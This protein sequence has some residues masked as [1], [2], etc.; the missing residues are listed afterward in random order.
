LNRNKQTLK[1]RTMEVW[2]Q[3]LTSL[4]LLQR[5]NRLL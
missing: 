4:H 1:I 3:V 2:I 5:R